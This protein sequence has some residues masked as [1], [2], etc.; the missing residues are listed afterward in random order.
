[1][2]VISPAAEFE[3]AESHVLSSPAGEISYTARP[4]YSAASE[5]LHFP[6]QA[7]CDFLSM[8][9]LQSGIEKVRD[10]YIVTDVSFF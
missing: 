4:V 10:C 2:Q 9:F 6:L 1:M 7:P 8:I 3:G 5:Y